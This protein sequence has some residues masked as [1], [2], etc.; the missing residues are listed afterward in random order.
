MKPNPPWLAALW[1]AFF[2]LT[3]CRSPQ[4]TVRHTTST[5]ESTRNNCYSLLYQLLEDEKNVSLLRFIKREPE[6][7]KILVK[8]IATHA[9]TGAKLL[10][11]LARQ[12]TSLR[13]DDVRLPLGEIATRDAIAA[14]KEK[15][16][17]SQTGAEFEVSLLLTQTEALNYASHLAKVA[18]ENEPHPDRAQALASI[19]RDMQTLYQ[20]AFALLLARKNNPQPTR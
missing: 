12:D 8:K 10:E 11:E 2:V 19:S 13:L 20:E 15:A 3:A 1:L 14:T 16:L 4:T 5:V 7:L 9:G 18:S 6:D 17:L